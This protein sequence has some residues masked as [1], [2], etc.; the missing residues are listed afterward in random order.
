MLKKVAMEKI[1]WL[2]IKIFSNVP[3]KQKIE[4]YLLELPE[5]KKKEKTQ[6]G[7]ADHNGPPKHCGANIC[8][9]K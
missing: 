2:K 6:N 1:I 4:K 7:L 9:L 3:L 5:G 8:T